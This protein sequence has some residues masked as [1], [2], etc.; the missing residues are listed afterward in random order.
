MWRAQ[1]SFQEDLE[2][3]AGNDVESTSKAKPNFHPNHNQIRTNPNQN[4]PRIEVKILPKYDSK[5]SPKI[6]KKRQ[7]NLT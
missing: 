5:N 7:Q 6:W 1:F 4:S 2:L 3:E